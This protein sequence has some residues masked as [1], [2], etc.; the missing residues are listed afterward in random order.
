MCGC[1]TTAQDAVCFLGNRRR[2]T[3]AELFVSPLQSLLPPEKSSQRK[4]TYDQVYHLWVHLVHGI[5]SKPTVDTHETVG[6]APCPQAA[7]S[8]METNI[9]RHNTTMDKVSGDIFKERPQRRQRHTEER[10]KRESGMG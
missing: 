9:K 8:A 10:Q 2:D 4:R 1:V 3:K 7:Y 5:D 6:T